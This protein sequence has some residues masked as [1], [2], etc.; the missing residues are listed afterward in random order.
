MY[1][2]VFRFLFFSWRAD[3]RAQKNWEKERKQPNLFFMYLENMLALFITSPWTGARQF[4]YL[5][6]LHKIFQEQSADPAIFR[7]SYATHDDVFDQQIGSL[8]GAYSENW[9]RPQTHPLILGLNLK[10]VSKTNHHFSDHMGWLRSR[11]L[12]KFL[13]DVSTS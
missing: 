11:Y 3:E 12:W 5:D 10:L 9:M 8:I 4:L 13:R 7:N 1:F 6:D 2:Q